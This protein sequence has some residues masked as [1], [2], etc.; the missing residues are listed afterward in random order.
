VYPKYK[1]IDRMATTAQIEERLDPEISVD[2][3]TMDEPDSVP[4][5]NCLCNMAIFSVASICGDSA[6]IV[7]VIH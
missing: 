2:L 1:K 5:S 7:E 4:A 3:P 6:D